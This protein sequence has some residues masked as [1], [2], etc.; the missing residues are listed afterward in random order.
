MEKTICCDVLLKSWLTTGSPK[1]TCLLEQSFPHSRTFYCLVISV[2]I[3]IQNLCLRIHTCEVSH[4]IIIPCMHGCVSV[5]YRWC[6]KRT[7]LCINVTLYCFT[8]YSFALYCIMLYCITV[9]VQSY[10]V[11]PSRCITS[12]YM[13]VLCHTV[14]YQTP[15]YHIVLYVSQFIVSPCIVSCCFVSHCIWVTLNCA[16]SCYISHCILLNCNCITVLCHI[17]LYLTVLCH[18]VLYHRLYCVTL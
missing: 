12:L 4:A 10:T 2:L 7:R 13:S 9:P 1:L 16:A 17:V 15:L 14:S 5:R 18:T 8:R 6:F 3:Q 11:F